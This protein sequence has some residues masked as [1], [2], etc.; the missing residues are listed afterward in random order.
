METQLQ[1]RQ[2]AQEVQDYLKDLFE[3]QKSQQ[4]K[5]KELQLAPEPAGSQEP[6]GSGMAAA[7]SVPAPRGR[8]VTTSVA[9]APVE[10]QTP[11]LN[12][13]KNGA[14]QTADSKPGAGTKKKTKPKTASN[15]RNAAAHTYTSYSK[16]DKLD[17]DA[18]LAS[19]SEQSEAGAD[20]EEEEAEQQQEVPMQGPGA[21]AASVVPAPRAAMPMQAPLKPASTASMQ[22]QHPPIRNS[23]P[24]TAEAWKARGNDLFKAGQFASAKECYAHCA[25]MEPSNAVAYANKA[26]AELKLQEWAEAEADCTKALELDPSYVKVC[27]MIARVLDAV[28]ALHD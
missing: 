28:F 5:D 25:A 2:N 12:V 22:P 15:G 4:Q 13:H 21:S 16:W 10:L 23:E 11:G 8:A 6:S 17:V 14:S 9:A 1:I 7:A 24:Q 20:V 26:M 19:D 27:L 3:W 18:M